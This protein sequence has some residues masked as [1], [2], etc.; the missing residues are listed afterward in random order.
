MADL[1]ILIG[2]RTVSTWSLRAWI[3]LKKTGE[4]FDETLVRY[5]T[6]E[7][8]AELNR[9][10]PT[11]KV[12]LLTDRRGGRNI[13]V[14]DS[15]AICEYLAEQFPKA[16]LWPEDVAARAL[17]RSMSAEM[18]SGFRPLREH[19]SMALLERFPGQ[20]IDGKGVRDDI[21]RIEALWAQ[22]RAYGSKVGGPFLFGHFTIADAMFLPVATRFRTYQPK[23]SPLA[24]AYVDAVLADPDFL[25]WENQAKKDPTPEPP[26]P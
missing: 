24:Q 6:I 21:A 19:F 12:P 20:G 1:H 5:R 2:Y 3:A 4:A 17:A 26:T 23:L 16:R 7:G 18:H 15:I 11:G 9:L 13:K 25:V 14:W 22:A 10:S 8:K